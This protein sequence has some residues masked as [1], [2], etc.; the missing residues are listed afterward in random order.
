[1]TKCK[2]LHRELGAMQLSSPFSE[3]SKLASELPKI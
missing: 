2:D 1:M 3:G